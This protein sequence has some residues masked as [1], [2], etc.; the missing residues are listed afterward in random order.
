MLWDR[1]VDSRLT[2]QQQR[3]ADHYRVLDKGIDRLAD[4]FPGSPAKIE[5]QGDSWRESDFFRELD[6]AFRME[7]RMDLRKG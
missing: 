4:P 1:R 7:D 2:R 3:V 5:R 6:E